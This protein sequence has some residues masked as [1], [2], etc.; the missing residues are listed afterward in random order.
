MIPASLWQMVGF[1]AIDPVDP[2]IQAFDGFIR[3]LFE[4]DL[5]TTRSA[6]APWRGGARQAPLN[7]G[8]GCCPIESIE[9][10]VVECTIGNHGYTMDKPRIYHGYTMDI[11]WNIPWNIP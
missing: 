10:V 3:H 5:E 1:T 7:H 9:I 6:V 11:L 8:I 2:L 4:E